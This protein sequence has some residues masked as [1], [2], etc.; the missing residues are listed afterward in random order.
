M[1][2]RKPNFPSICIR[3]TMLLTLFLMVCLYV[4]VPYCCV[5]RS[6]MSVLWTLESFLVTEWHPALR[7][8]E[9]GHNTLQLLG[10][11]PM[12][13]KTLAGPM[14]RYPQYHSL[15][16]DGR[17]YHSNTYLP[18]PWRNGKVFKQ[19]WMSRIIKVWWTLWTYKYLITIMPWW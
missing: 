18:I 2:Y 16:S 6:W 5:G 3:K 1:E 11:K 8:S 10:G 12:E 19:I 13:R 15:D 14:D 9:E 4:A 17:Q 7:S